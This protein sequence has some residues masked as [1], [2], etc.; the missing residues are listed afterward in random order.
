MSDNTFEWWAAIGGEP[1]MYDGP[2]SSR[3]D[4]IAQME[5]EDGEIYGFT[6]CEA[7]KQVLSFHVFDAGEVLEKVEEHN[8]E[9][10]GDDGMNVAPTHAQE[11]DL[12]A[13]LAA[14]VR[15]WMQRHNLLPSVWAFGVMRNMEYF[16]PTKPE[17]VD[18][19]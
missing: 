10:W 12:E 5:D 6:V 11:D 4:A 14:T 7:D 17:P 1:E 2:F 16:P 19:E 15:D 9:C 13:A 3:E 8:N 18:G